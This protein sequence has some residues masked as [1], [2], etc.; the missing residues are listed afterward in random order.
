M[1]KSLSTACLGGVGNPSQTLLI[2]FTIITIMVQIKISHMLIII[3]RS[4]SCVVAYLMLKLDWS[5][6]K[7][8]T[9]IREKRPIQVIMM[10]VTIVMIMMIMMMMV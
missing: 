2:I 7:A 8:L 4:T 3:F 10:M 5:A 6:L 9:H 1:E